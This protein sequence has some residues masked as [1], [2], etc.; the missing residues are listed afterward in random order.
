MS[1]DIC[2][3]CNRPLADTG[4]AA[5]LPRIKRR[6]FEA[7]ANAG[8]MGINRFEIMDKVYGDDPDGG[9][10]NDFIIKVHIS[11][12]NKRIREAGLHI[13][14]D[15]VGPRNPKLYRLEEIACGS[16]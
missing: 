2:P 6:I 15:R 10:D 16:S 1:N 5:T 8:E 11:Q 9:P 7:V 12:I 13:T 3:T 14:G 4:I